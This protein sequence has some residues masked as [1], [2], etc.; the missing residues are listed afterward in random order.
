M[1]DLAKEEVSGDDWGEGALAVVVVE[2]ITDL[3][4]EGFGDVV[5]EVGFDSL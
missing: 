5:V 4:N 1:E 2:V 3:A